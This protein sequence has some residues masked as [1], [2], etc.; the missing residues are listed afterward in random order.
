MK[1]YKGSVFF[2]HLFVSYVLFISIL[3]L[4]GSGF[5]RIESYLV[6]FCSAS[7]SIVYLCYQF[8]RLF[9]VSI[10]I[11]GICGFCTKLLIGYMF[12]QFYMWPDYFSNQNSTIVF[13]HYEFL[14]TPRS[15]EKIADY[16]TV[17]GFFS[18]P[19]DQVVF[20]GKYFFINYVM[21]NLFMSGNVNL[22]DFSIQSALFS[23]YTAI[24]VSLIGIRL[25]CTKRQAKLIFI[26][27]LFQPFSFNSAIIWRDVVGQFFVFIG[28][29]L[30]LLSSEAKFMKAIILLFISALSMAFLRTVYIFIPFFLYSVKYLREGINSVK[31][32]AIFLTLSV[33]G[34]FI[35]SSTNLTDFVGAG[36]SSYLGEAANLK[37]IL[38][39]PIDFL[40]AI[41]GPFPWINWFEFTDNTIFLISHYLQAVYVVVIL[42]FTVRHYKLYNNEFKLYLAL[43]CLIFLTTSVTGRDIHA[44]YF[45]FAVALLLP[46]SIR[47]LSIKRFVVSYI[48]VFYGFIVMNIIYLSLGFHGSNLGAIL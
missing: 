48:M 46:I 4:L 36:Y 24:I 19:L 37:F 44:N 17:N 16:R 14:F 7:L 27:A 22:L 1:N 41:I 43:L 47:Y 40:R 30:I 10:L 28:V 21:S 6:A 15:M 35:I 5:D 20:Q 23:F 8:R 39:L 33:L 45:S 34:L 31:R 32:S 12:W 18:V 29:Y 2:T 3:L 26:I 25:G 42:F 9:G 38:L 13:D 11:V